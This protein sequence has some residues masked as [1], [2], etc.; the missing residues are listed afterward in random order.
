LKPLYLTEVSDYLK[1]VFKPKVVTGIEADD[2]V[3]MRAYCSP[4]AVIVGVDKDYRGQP[5]QFFDV[6]NPEEGIING[7]CFGE[8]IDKGK[9]IS[10]Y[11]RIFMYWQMLA[12]DSS[13]HYTANCHSELKYADKKAY[14]ALADC[15]DDKEALQS[16]IEEFKKMY[17]EPIEIQTWRDNKVLID[18][19]Y[20]AN[21][22]FQMAR[23]LRWEGD[24]MSF[25]QW[26]YN[27]NVKF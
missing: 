12:G 10:G 15:K 4:D 25:D 7:G 20:V 13:D 1:H 14:K 5:I 2:A 18:W 24:S 27:Y 3:V 19:Y 23:M 26:C 21:E 11:G 17:P 8:L 22:M 16:V 6:N 9:K